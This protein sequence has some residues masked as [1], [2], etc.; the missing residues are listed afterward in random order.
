MKRF[1]VWFGFVAMLAALC[2]PVTAE[3]L[4]GPRF[5]LGNSIH[6]NPAFISG[7]VYRCDLEFSEQ[8][9]DDPKTR[10]AGLN[11]F[12]TQLPEGYARWSDYFVFETNFPLGGTGPGYETQG[13]WCNEGSGNPGVACQQMCQSACQ[14]APGGHMPGAVSPFWMDLDSQNGVEWVCRCQ[15]T[16]GAWGYNF[17]DTCIKKEKP[18]KAPWCTEFNCPVECVEH[19]N[20][21]PV[22]P[23]DCP[24]DECLTGCPGWPMCLA[25][26]CTPSDCWKHCPNY[27]SGCEDPYDP[28]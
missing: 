5:R 26:Q 9:Y 1:L 11:C 13:D 25:A 4:T 2:G 12:Q 21:P 28:L 20:C 6:W 27:D 22:D 24:E 23:A 16:G 17:K 8:E 7:H 18:P 19:P 15:C 3:E 10:Y 14:N